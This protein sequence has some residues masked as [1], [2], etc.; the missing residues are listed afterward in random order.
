VIPLEAAAGIGLTG[1]A[2]AGAVTS[3]TRAIAAIVSFEVIASP[4]GA[5]KKRTERG[6]AVAGDVGATPPSRN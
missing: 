4:G 6:S 2:F 5:V 1:I 3:A